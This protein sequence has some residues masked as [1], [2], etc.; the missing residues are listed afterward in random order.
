RGGLETTQF[1][2]CAPGAA[3]QFQVFVSD[4]ER[5]LFARA[6][7]YYADAFMRAQ[8]KLARLP[9][10]PLPGR[11]EDAEAV[12]QSLLG[13]QASSALSTRLLNDDATV[14]RYSRFLP[15]RA[16]LVRYHFKL[17]VFA[18]CSGD[19]DT[20]QRCM[21]LAYVH[22]AAYVGE[23]AAGAYLPADD[24]GHGWMW[25]LNGGDGDGQ[26]A[27]NLRMFGARW[28]EALWL[29]EALHVRV[30]RGWLYQSLDVGALRATQAHQQ[31]YVVTA[32]H[33][34][35][36]PT[37]SAQRGAMAISPGGQ[38]PRSASPAGGNASLDALVLS[39]HAGEVNA[40][41]EQLMDFERARHPKP[42]RVYYVALGSESRD[43]D[44]LRAP[45]ARACGW[46]PLGGF[47]AA[48][49][50]GL[51]LSS[52]RDISSV[53]SMLPA[54]SAY[55]ACLALAGRQCVE[56]VRLLACVLRRGGFGEDSSY[57]W[58][59][60]ER[61]YRMHA[62]LYLVAEA[63][64][65][66]FARALNRTVLRLR[67]E[68]NAN[69]DSTQLP[70]VLVASLRQSLSANVVPDT[71]GMDPERD[72]DRTHA[73]STAFA[74]FAFDRALSGVDAEAKPKLP[75]DDALF[76]LWMWPENASHVFHAAALA[77]LRRSRQ[78][79]A[80]AESYS[81]ES[82]S[83]HEQPRVFSANPGVENTYVSAWLA[84]ERQRSADEGSAATCQLL[85]A[86]LASIDAS[87]LTARAAQAVAAQA[88]DL[89]ALHELIATRH[90]PVHAI[91]QL[92]SECAEVYAG[93]G[94]HATALA[95]FELLATQF[96]TGDWPR[97]TA[98]ALQWAVECALAVDASLSAARAA[99]ELLSPALVPS[100]A[101]R[102]R[103]AADL[104]TMLTAELVV[105]MA[106]VYAPIRAHA[107]WRHWGVG[108]RERM[109]F[110]VAIDCSAMQTSLPLDALTV[111]FSDARFNVT[112]TP[113][114]RV[115][116]AEAESVRLYELDAADGQACPLEL[117]AACTTVIQGVVLFGSERPPSGVLV[118][119]AIT[120]SLFGGHLRLHWPT[121]AGA[122]PGDD[123][124]ADASAAE[125]ALASVE[126]Q[127]LARIGV[128]RVRDSTRG[129]LELRLP[130][131]SDPDVPAL[132]RAVR[133]DGPTD[134][135]PVECGWLR[136][137]EGR[138]QW[139]QL[140]TPPLTLRA[141]TEPAFSAYSRCRVLALRA[142]VPALELRLP[143]VAAQAPAYGGE[144][145]PVRIEVRNVHA[146][147]TLAAVRVNVRL[148][149]TGPDSDDGSGSD[150][151]S[152]R[153]ADKETPWLLMLDTESAPKQH[154]ELECGEL[155]PQ[156]VR[157]LSV[158]VQFPTAALHGAGRD[159][160]PTADVAVL[161]CTVCDDTG[162]ET[163]SAQASIPV[164]QP[165]YA[166]IEPLLPAQMPKDTRPDAPGS[167]H[168][169]RRAVRVRLGNAGP[170]D[171]QIER[172]QLRPARL[173]ARSV[174][175]VRVAGA[176]LA[177]EASVVRAGATQ[178]HVF[179][180]DIQARDLVRMPETVW[181]GTLEVQWQREQQKDAQGGTITTCLW[182]PA[183]RL[184]RRCVQV[185]L[186]A[187]ATCTVGQP[188]ALNY[189]VLNA[190]RLAHTVEAA[191][192]ASDIFVFAGARRSTL[193][194]LP[195]HSTHL[196][197]NVVPLVANSGESVW[198]QL[199]RL[200]V[201][202]APAKRPLSGVQSPA[203][204]VQAMTPPPTRER[205]SVVLDAAAAQRRVQALAGVDGSLSPGLA[206][207]CSDMLAECEL[208][209]ATGAES[210]FADSDIEDLPVEV[211]AADVSDEVVRY[212]STLVF[213]LP[214]A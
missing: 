96:R 49:D 95:M 202:L 146:T 182:L 179:W 205:S 183:Q 79:V 77:S 70:S 165:L 27:H 159:A 162:D 107:H 211:S 34:S 48:T 64:G 18:E 204:S 33:R 172:V 39:V 200:D 9:Q 208:D 69:S 10:L 2:V 92:A 11:P 181:P 188:F 134:S 72:T 67:A 101:E 168:S 212:D 26:R 129:Q 170:W 147:R 150:G 160:A 37:V 28:D 56:H 121:C 142:P 104:P 41:T 87:P 55:D 35:G 140:P 209:E 123:D 195:G 174:V 120:A 46:W 192:H 45:D 164:V 144:R 14:T 193:T 155:E 12:R 29:L 103:I 127:L 198:A 203:Q 51:V 80:E 5:A 8:A 133:V 23:I 118:L 125:N 135:L 122:R 201:R 158:F 185:D 17:G 138:A 81:S 213:C 111:E 43:V 190:T 210:D 189:R 102:A 54:R 169:F 73:P 214:S 94:S 71:S 119:E 197:F 15:V 65:M 194:L 60:V 25:A 126:K 136:V 128:A 4:L 199:P 44:L 76:P 20:A 57:F 74:G 130:L 98:H 145:F 108:A 157:V 117:A 177:H 171:V 139:E 124:A 186:D 184:L 83:D 21:W 156:A 6:T 59:M 153:D 114:T 148:G 53:A 62:A 141:G 167:E 19:R 50:I 36:P 151:D 7:T 178:D 13:D 58:A 105:D 42:S 89:G 100:R 149:V 68:D 85:A 82:A 175:E 116:V 90:E 31:R 88:A 166:E 161:K 38:S 66:G 52:S 91:R 93:A 84:S 143:D 16:W 163:A 154:L 132:R 176:A 63:H 106:Q 113:E 86:T 206:A 207:A 137:D 180:L 32:V 173:D 196:R 115:G 152:A 112:V 30:A 24:A 75:A 61:Q 40:A 47:Y 97:L 109:Q 1:A 78:L 22:L 99:V 187:P 191:M 131:P 110:Q 3:A